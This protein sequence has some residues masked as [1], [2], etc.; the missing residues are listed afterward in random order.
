MTNGWKTIFIILALFLVVALAAIVAERAT[1]NAFSRECASKMRN[2]QAAKEQ[3]AKAKGKPSYAEPSWHDIKS[4]LKGGE[5]L[6]CPFRAEYDLG[7]VDEKPR[8]TY[9]DGT[10][11][12]WR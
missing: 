12:V 10:V 1:D 6:T 7:P 5:K 4:Y 9:G 8:C 2:I 11:H 3:W